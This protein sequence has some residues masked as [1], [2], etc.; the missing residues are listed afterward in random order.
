MVPRVATTDRLR[1]LNGSFDAVTAK[2]LVDEITD[3]LAANERGWVSTVNVASLMMMRGSPFLQ[4]H[5]DESTWVVADGQ[6]LVW[7]SRVFR[8]R[9][10]ERVAGVDVIGAL[11]ERAAAR[12]WPVFM[13]GASH[14][15][16]QAAADRLRTDHPGLVVECAD[17]YFAADAAADTAD[18]VA[19]FGPAILFVGMGVPRQERFIADHW[20][21]LGA[22]VAI[23]VGGSFDVLAGVRRRAPRWMQRASLE[24]VYRTMQEPRRL[25]WRYASTGTKFA[26][27]VVRGLALPR[28]RTR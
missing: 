3:R 22:G 10:P 18:A 20:H 4:R 13:L 7:L 24:W 12:E 15:V 6:P 23:G 25:L 27:L 28:Y 19:S 9:L 2:E 14:D 5:V 1:I 26:V 16:I 11:C 21:R 8:T 17:G